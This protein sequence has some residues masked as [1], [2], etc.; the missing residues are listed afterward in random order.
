MN[1]WKDSFRFS[2]SLQ[3]VGMTILLVLSCMILVRVY[4]GVIRST[5]HSKIL[6]ESIQASRNLAEEY[7]AK[8]DLS[9]WDSPVIFLDRDMAACSEDGA[10][11]KIVL[12]EDVTET[13]TGRICRLT[14]ESIPMSGSQEDPVYSL[15]TEVFVPEED[16]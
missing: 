14:I 3:M 12:S 6:S 11:L 1:N 7:Q 10:Y 2:L 5:Q 4:A 9:D 16:H 13:A 8:P 15:S